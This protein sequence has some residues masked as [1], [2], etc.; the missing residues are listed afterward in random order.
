MRRRNPASLNLIVRRR[1]SLV[2]HP[3]VIRRQ[4]LRVM[5]AVFAA[6]AI[7]IAGFILL[8]IILPATFMGAILP[9]ADRP[10]GSGMFLVLTVPLAGAIS[11]AAMVILA[12]AFYVRLSPR[13]GGTT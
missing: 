6:L 3:I 10:I 13:N 8:A 12:R 1:P 5:L 11:I 9:W 2:P 4:W 7:S